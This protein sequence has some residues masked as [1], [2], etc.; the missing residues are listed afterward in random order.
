MD[1]SCYVLHWRISVKEDLAWATERQLPCA[2]KGCQLVGI[3]VL[4]SRLR[5]KVRIINLY[6]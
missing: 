5:V 3:R 4:G 6:Q 2:M 1:S